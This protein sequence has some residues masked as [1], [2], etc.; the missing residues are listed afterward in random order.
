[1]GPARCSAALTMALGSAA[2]PAVMI[3]VRPSADRDIPGWGR[4]TVETL[5]SDRS[6]SVARFTT[7]WAAGSE[8]IGARWSTTTT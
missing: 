6:K 2:A 3:P 4:T 5:G 7:A 1:M 8:L